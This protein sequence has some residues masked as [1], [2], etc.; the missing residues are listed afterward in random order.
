MSERIYKALPE[1]FIRCMRNWARAS[2]GLLSVAGLISGIYRGERFGDGYA[3]AQIPIL[4]GEAEDVERA[5]NAL[6]IRFRQAVQLFWWWEGDR[7]MRRIERRLQ[8]RNGT[9]EAWIMRG[10]ELLRDQLSANRHYR[11]LILP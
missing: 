11:V 6:P 7:V 1:H 2:C 3:E 8:L 4:H 10:H 5:L 9:A